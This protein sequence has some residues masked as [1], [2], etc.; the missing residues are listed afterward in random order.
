M[1]RRNRLIASAVLGLLALFT[2][3]LYLLTRESAAVKVP[4][5]A[6]Y[7]T[8]FLIG[9]LMLAAGRLQL[10]GGVAITGRPARGMGLA[11]VLPLLVNFALPRLG[12]GL[13]ALTRPATHLALLLAVGVGALVLART[14]RAG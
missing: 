12:G 6:V 9:A 8:L 3:V 2:G 4:G 5:S 7:G 10:P 1:E 11:W 14:L 13:A